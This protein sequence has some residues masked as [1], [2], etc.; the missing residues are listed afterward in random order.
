M[1]S[2]VTKDWPDEDIWIGMRVQILATGDP[3]LVVY[4]SGAVETKPVQ[5]VCNLTVPPD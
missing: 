4:K 1:V 5:E 2:V 3:N